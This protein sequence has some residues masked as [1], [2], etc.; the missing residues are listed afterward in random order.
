M[1]HEADEVFHKTMGTELQQVLIL[2]FCITWSPARFLN[3]CMN[4]VGHQA[5]NSLLNLTRCIF[6]TENLRVKTVEI[7]FKSLYI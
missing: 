7:S 2:H 4:N 3:N 6:S 5:L 1:K